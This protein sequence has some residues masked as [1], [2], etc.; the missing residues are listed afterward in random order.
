MQRHKTLPKCLLPK[1]LIRT[2]S[3]TFDIPLGTRNYRSSLRSGRKGNTRTFWPPFTTPV[4]NQRWAN[5]PTNRWRIT[6]GNHYGLCQII[7]QFSREKHDMKTLAQWLAK[8]L[9]ATVQSSLPLDSTRWKLS[10]LRKKLNSKPKTRWKKPNS[11]ILAF[12][13]N[14]WK[15]VEPLKK[16]CLYHASEI[17]TKSSGFEKATDQ[18]Y[19]THTLRCFA[20]DG[21][22][23]EDFQGSSTAADFPGIH[24]YFPF[25]YY[26]TIFSTIRIISLLSFTRYTGWLASLVRMVILHRL[27]IIETDII[28]TTALKTS[29]NCTRNQWNRNSISLSNTDSTTYRFPLLESVARHRSARCANHLIK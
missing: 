28:E 9:E 6:V 20:M 27:K 13:Q 17:H 11:D 10:R 7:W 3:L 12:S 22:I 4:R 25:I 26:W 16:I 23:S 2:K 18:P 5:V 15:S 21:I 19:T 29:S 1:I 8:S 24:K 14:S